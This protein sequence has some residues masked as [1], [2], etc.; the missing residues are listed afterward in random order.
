MAIGAWHLRPIVGTTA[1]PV[2]KTA[3]NLDTALSTWRQFLRDERTISTDDADELE[4]HLRDQV[5][6]LV[7][8]GMDPELAFQIAIGHMGSYTRLKKDFQQVYWKKLRAEQNLSNELI[9]RRDMFISYIR[10]AF[11]A[12]GKHKLYTFINVFG[13]TIG[14]LCCCL[15][16]VYV[17]YELS[18]DKHH[19]HADR[20]VRIAEDLK[21]SDQMLYQASTSPPMGPA[22]V[23]DFPEVEAMVRIRHTGRLFQLGDSFFEDERLMYA[24]S[25]IF[26]IFS[27]TVKQG[28]LERALAEP[29]SIVLTETAAQKYFGDA[30]ALGQVLTDEHGT[31]YTV[32]AVIEDPPDN[33]HIRF[34]GL[35]SMVSRAEWDADWEGQWFSNNYYTYLL[36]REGTDVAALEAKTPDFIERRIGDYQ[37]EIGSGYTLLPLIP[38]TDIHLSDHRARGFGTNG[39]KMNLYILGLVALFILVLACINFMNLA[40]AR[41]AER[42]REVALRKVVGA[43]RSQLTTQ[44]LSESILMTLFAV[45]LSVGLCWVLLPHFANFAGRELSART[46]FTGWNSLYLLGFVLVVGFLAG[47][48]PALVLSRFRP[49]RVLKGTISVGRQRS[50]LRKSLVVFQFAI[51][52]IFIISTA[53]VMRQLEY[54]QNQDLGFTEEQVLVI[55]FKGDHEV[56]AQS[57]TIKQVFMDRTDVRA[58]SISGSIP[59]GGYSNWYTNV[60]VE[61]GDVRDASLG[62]YVIDF[63][64]VDTYELDIIAG[65]NVSSAFPTDSLQGLLINKAMADHFGWSPQEALGKVFTVGR[66]RIVVGVV[67]NFNYLSLHSDI[68]PLG[69]LF[70]SGSHRYLSLRLQ[71]DTVQQT[72]AELEGIWQEQIPHRPFHAYFAD[73]FFNWQYETEMKFG[74]LFRVFAILAIIIACLGLFGLTAFTVQRRTREIGI[75]KVLGAS[76]GQMV[77]L[78]SKDYLGLIG[79]AFIVAVPASYV[80]AEQWLSSFPYRAQWSLVIFLMA[81]VIGFGIAALTVSYQTIRTAMANPAHAIRHE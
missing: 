25:T 26:D 37:R 42:A 80:L 75:R 10:T 39:Q 73:E 5:D 19:E 78:L 54:L 23:E 56:L 43:H 72:M 3:F 62:Y 18:F 52:M 6:D 7:G 38:L 61:P 41:S 51:S 32:T 17:H 79:I 50:V 20:I 63:D 40:T 48:Y 53:I 31:G 57:E 35:L 46:L 47:G 77:T 44:F 27:F 30:L 13:L 8:G 59:G 45:L 2:M 65:R 76:A 34:D 66:D 16:F 24:D 60:E 15:L 71:T 4:C 68:Q 1:E 11:R 69:L 58:A 70:S 33:T 12:M 22:F 81:G 49:I 64:F 14:V 67:D 28:G 74:L 9:W 36:L 21:T 55:N 29:F